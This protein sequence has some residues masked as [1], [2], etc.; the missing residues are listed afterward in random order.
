[1]S[2]S[3]RPLCLDHRYGPRVHVLDD[4]FTRTLLARVGSPA[5]HPPELLELVRSF[6]RLLLARVLAREFP[7]AR[8]SEP[9]RMIEHTPL[10]VWADEGLDPNVEIVIANVLRAGAVPSLAVYEEIGRILPAKNVRID[11]FYFAR[12]ADAAGRVIGVDAAGS[13]IG[14]PLAGRVLL[15]PDPM[16]ATG[17]T[18]L[19]V[20]ETYKKRDLGAPSI[21]VAM[22]LIVTP[23]SLRLLAKEAPEL[24]VYAGRVDRGM[25]PP[26]VLAAMPGV[27][28]DRERG[29]S[30]HDY[31]VPG[32]G[33]L[34]E[35]L[36]NSWC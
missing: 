30:D 29:L 16:G 10:G 6:Y 14:G 4:A 34:G 15:V 11:H 12:I 7:L 36:T 20:L 2:A 5:A 19:R 18:V 27:H 35:V 24:R 17:S 33:G 25:S 9:T 32:A 26:D 31:I 13:K 8:R 22:H 21:A 1:M 3:D 23:E 28:F